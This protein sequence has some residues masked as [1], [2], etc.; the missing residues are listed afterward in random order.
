MNL[1][2]IIPD[3]GDRPKFL[4]NCLRMMDAQTLKPKY[5][6]VI[7]FPAIDDHVDITPRYKTGYFWMSAMDIDLVAFIEN[8]D[9]YSPDYLET[10]VE[11]WKRFEKPALFGTCFTIYYHLELKAYFTMEHTQR[12]SAMN[13]FIKPGIN[14]KWPVDMEPFLDMHLWSGNAGI[15][16]INSRI[17]FRPEKI[18]SVGM[19]HGQGKTIGGGMHVV[20]DRVKKKYATKDVNSDYPEGFLKTVLDPESFNFYN[21]YFQ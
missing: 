19:K 6:R 13:T 11:A 4:E 5:I 7:D 9:W 17:V 12:A 16:G 10:M 18:I 2:I 3:R 15:T 14:I 21:T 20:D 1:G 8:D